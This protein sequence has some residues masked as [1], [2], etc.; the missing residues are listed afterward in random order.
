MKKAVPLFVVSALAL[1]LFFVLSPKEEGDR[2]RVTLAGKDMGEYP[3][4]EDVR[5]NIEGTSNTFVIE[6]GRVKMVE[7]DCPDRICIKEGWKSHNHETI[8][9]L[10]NKI[11]IEVIKS[12]DTLD[13]VV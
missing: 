5:V 9:C 3:L 13:L 12:E 10:P 11:V 4:S 7:A 6:K 1:V 2:V 8:T